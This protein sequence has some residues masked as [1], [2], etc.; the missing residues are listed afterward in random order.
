VRINRLFDVCAG[1]ATNRRDEAIANANITSIP[2]R[3]RAIDDVP[4]AMT[5]S[6]CCELCAKAAASSTSPKQNDRNYVNVEAL[7]LG[8]EFFI[9]HWC[10]LEWLILT[11]LS[12]FV[13]R[14]YR[15]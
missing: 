12:D 5:R 7:Q 2:R 9:L 8:D 6:N 3:T 15:L 11:W 10:G 13:N 1:K 4:L 14:T